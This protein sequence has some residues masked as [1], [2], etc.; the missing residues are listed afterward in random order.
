MQSCSISVG[1][2][3]S[4]VGQEICPTYENLHEKRREY[5]PPFHTTAL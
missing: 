2:I 3:F 1:L 5:F 4:I